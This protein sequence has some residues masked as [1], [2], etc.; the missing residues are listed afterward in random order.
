MGAD[1]VVQAFHLPKAPRL[2]TDLESDLVASTVQNLLSEGHES[3]KL[4]LETMDVDSDLDEALVVGSA[5]S[6]TPKTM[7]ELAEDAA[8]LQV[9][10][11]EGRGG[12]GGSA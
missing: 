2:D 9:V 5:T 4:E 3:E 12:G 6:H 11:E 7:R 8:R 10:D 1:D